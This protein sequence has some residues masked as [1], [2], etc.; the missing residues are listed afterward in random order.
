MAIENIDDYSWYFI[1][2]LGEKYKGMID[3]VD[4]N[5]SLIYYETEI[6]KTEIKSV[7]I[8]VEEIPSIIKALYKILKLKGEL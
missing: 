2:G 4:S 7:P 8:L 5:D 6:T 3:I 1:D